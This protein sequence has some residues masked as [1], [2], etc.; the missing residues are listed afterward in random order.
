MKQQ[1]RTE[2]Q[3]REAAPRRQ[4]RRT[5]HS[6]VVPELWMQPSVVRHYASCASHD[7]RTSELLLLFT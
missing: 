6:R 4:K 5:A 7:L 2:N 3:I 1:Q